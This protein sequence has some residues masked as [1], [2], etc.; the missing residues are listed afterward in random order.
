MTA[1]FTNKHTFHS[2]SMKYLQGDRPPEEVNPEPYVEPPEESLAQEWTDQEPPS[3]LE[4]D[5]QGNKFVSMDCP[6]HT[7]KLVSGLNP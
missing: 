6:G 1:P 4:S 7:S 3:S 5:E 2:K